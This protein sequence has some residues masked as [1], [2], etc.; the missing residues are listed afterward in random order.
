MINL[1]KSKYKR[2]QDQIEQLIDWENYFQLQ[3]LLLEIE[4]YVKGNNY[5]SDKKKVLYFNLITDLKELLK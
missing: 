2:Y 3:I 4:E 5:L 1:F